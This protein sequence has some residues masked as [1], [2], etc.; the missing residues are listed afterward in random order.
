[1]REPEWR[2]TGSGI[3]ELHRREVRCEVRGA[4]AEI[5]KVE[6]KTGPRKLRSDGSHA[7]G[8]G[9]LS[10]LPRFH[11]R[12]GDEAAAVHAEALA[13][14]GLLGKS[15]SRSERKRE[16]RSGGPERFR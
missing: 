15:S 3:G 4:R 14:V 12:F 2:K 8:R 5:R 11:D 10:A 9:L 6:V 1:M 13:G 7:A 16:Q